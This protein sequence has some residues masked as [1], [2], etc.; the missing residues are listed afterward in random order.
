M[1]QKK[2]YALLQETEIVLI[3]MQ[4][5]IVYMYIEALCRSTHITVKLQRQ[6][7]YNVDIFKLFSS[8]LI[9]SR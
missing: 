9:E 5:H 4:K 2:N 6:I 3:A 1:F 8:R 7:E